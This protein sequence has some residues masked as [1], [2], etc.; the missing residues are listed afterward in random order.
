[1]LLDTIRHV[2]MGGAKGIISWMV[3]LVEWETNNG[4]LSTLIYSALLT[5][6]GQFQTKMATIKESIYKFVVVGTAPDMSMA[7]KV[8][9]RKIHV[10]VSH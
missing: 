7:H 10:V 6:Y 9:K 1:M 3:H 2:G 4:I 5:I 8:P